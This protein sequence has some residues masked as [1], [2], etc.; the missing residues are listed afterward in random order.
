VA[1]VRYDVIVTAGQP[2]D[3][4]GHLVPTFPTFEAAPWD[5]SPTDG[6]VPEWRG[7]TDDADLLRRA[8]QSRSAASTFGDRASFAD[9]W[10]ANVPALAKAFPDDKNPYNASDADAALVAHLAFWTGRDVARIDRLMR[11][12][13]LARPKWDRE[14]YLPR[15]LARIL[16]AP[17]QVL[18][19]NPPEPPASTPRAEAE[20]PRQ[21]PVEGATIL[22]PAQQVDLFNGCVYVSAHHKVLIPGGRLLKPEQFKTNFGGYVLLMDNANQRVSRN[23][24]EAFTES[25]ALRPPSAHSICFRPDRPGGEIIDVAGKTYVNTWWPANIRRTQGDA[26]LF[27]DL[28]R[29]LRRAFVGLPLCEHLVSPQNGAGG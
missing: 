14:D 24:W 2:V 1:G 22:T 18:I 27:H 9:L 17:G 25:E 10:E 6:P 5:A 19:D 16:S 23:A 3:L 7:P 26:T 29:K 8:L 4:C 15:T 20:A 21:R 11:Q 12:S 13:A 28:L